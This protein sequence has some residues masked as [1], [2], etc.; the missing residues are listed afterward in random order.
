MG[1]EEKVF[2]CGA[3]SKD[4]GRKVCAINKLE[5]S[6]LIHPMIDILLQGE[7]KEIR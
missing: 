2:H 6:D 3:S 5:N 1:M 4:A 7:D